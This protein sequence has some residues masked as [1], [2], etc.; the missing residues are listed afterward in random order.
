MRMSFTNQHGHSTVRVV[1][2]WFAALAATTS[3]LATGLTVIASSSASAAPTVVVAGGGRSPLVA[4]VAQ[5]ALTLTSTS[6]TVGTSLALTSKGGS[7]TGAVTYVINTSG[8]AGCLIRYGKLDAA[9]A[10]TC[11]LTATK[12]ADATYL[13]A[14]SPPTKV[15]FAAAPLKAQAALTLTS[16]SG[17]VG[18]ALALTSGGGSGTGAVTYVINSSGTAGCLI[19]YG[20][21]DAT[22]AGTCTLTATKAADVTYL[23]ASSPPTKVTFAPSPLA[24]QAALTLTSTSGTVGTALALTSG[25]GSGSGVVTYTVT[26]AGSASCWITG[27]QLHATRGGACIV[28][29]NKAADTKYS[30]AS[31]LPTKVTFTGTVVATHLTCSGE[32]GLVRVGRTV[33]VSIFGAHF[34]SKP[35]IRSTQ[36]GTIADVIHDHGNELVVRVSLRTGATIGKYVFRVTLANGSTC[37]VQ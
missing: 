32:Y 14:S 18:T 30:T 29:V 10:G 31:S 24:T 6:G 5:A 37:S 26:N 35:T 36:I 1:L 13:A 4:Q 33:T 3:L 20:K 17:T 2:R 7:G 22:M 21:L 28:R 15:T 19:R 16:T 8:T 23:A 27:S 25:G 34:Y 11:T 9:R 12:A